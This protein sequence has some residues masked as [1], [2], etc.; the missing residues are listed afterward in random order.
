M[1][2]AAGRLRHHAP[3]ALAVFGPLSRPA[4]LTYGA[5]VLGLGLAY[6]AAAKAGL[7]LAYEN[8]SVTAVWPPTGIALAALVLGGRRLWPGVALGA[9]LANSWTG[10]PL[11]TVL[12]ITAGNTLEAVVGAHLLVRVARFRPSLDRARDVLALAVL[13]AGLSTLVSATVGVASL[14]AGHASW[15][16]ELASGWRTWW[17]GDLGGD[18]TV[19]PFILV[20]ATRGFRLDLRLSRILEGTLLL[21]VLVGVSSLVCSS[22]TSRGLPIWPVL[23]WAALRFRQRGV[24]VCSLVLAGISVSFTAQGV[25]PFAMGP[26]DTSL[27]VS[28]TFV[29]VTA[30]VALLLAAVTTERER[31]ETTLREAHDELEETV[32]ER[33]A[34]LRR[35]QVWMAEA[36]K[37]ARLGSWEWDIRAD[38]VTWSDELYE[39]YGVSPE[40]FEPSYRG[41]IDLVHTDDRAR[42]ESA[43]RDA[44]ADHQPFAFDERILRPD[45][46]VRTLASRGK[47][48]L[49]EDGRPARMLG[50]CQ[51]VT[52]RQREQEAL[53][54]AEEHARR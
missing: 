8:S 39:I 18:L 1:S 6:F 24:V 16:S 50:V 26:P 51:D 49:D 41:Y 42:V 5:K 19:A 35:S 48:F 3:S 38:T 11:I 25:G 2:A 9:F 21:A 30:I 40:D 10:V 44:F 4:A 17:L 13:A 29:G 12:G 37:I 14:Y 54:R 33:T 52:E 22:H 20:F 36:Q 27:L 15:R 7:A 34:V 47:V 43:I 53:R 28:Q 23:I 31:A 46:S 45:G 32:R